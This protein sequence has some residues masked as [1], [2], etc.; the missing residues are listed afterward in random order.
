M[1]CRVS[2]D[3]L[4]NDPPL[5]AWEHTAEQLISI[6]RN[7]KQGLQYWA[8]RVASSREHLSS[9]LRNTLTNEQSESL[10]KVYVECT[11]DGKREFLNAFSKEIVDYINK[12]E[13]T[14]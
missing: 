8:D 3:E 6:E 1:K 2:E 12:K 14:K 9:A 11:N 4:A 5:A 13:F 7:A 10:S